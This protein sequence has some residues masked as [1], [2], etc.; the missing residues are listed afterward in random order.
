MQKKFECDLKV[1]TCGKRLHPTGSIKY[2]EV[3]VYA[4]LSCQCQVNDPSV[5]LN[6][7]N[8]LLF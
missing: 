6:R 8:A 3:R 2:L 7:A 5:K 1:R 4:K